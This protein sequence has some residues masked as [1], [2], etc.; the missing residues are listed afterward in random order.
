MGGCVNQSTTKAEG[1]SKRGDTKILSLA[2]QLICVIEG[3]LHLVYP[4]YH[5]QCHTQKNG[6]DCSR[7][8]GI[9][10]EKIAVEDS[11]EKLKKL[12]PVND[13]CQ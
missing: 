9:T 8:R 5:E 11:D 6:G 7:S 2:Q 13:N 3:L 10:I 12:T 1:K 4:K